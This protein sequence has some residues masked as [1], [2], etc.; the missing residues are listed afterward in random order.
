MSNLKSN[1]YMWAITCL[2]PDDGHRVTVAYFSKKEEADKLCGTKAY[3]KDQ[4]VVQCTLWTDGD[5]WYQ[6]EMREVGVDTS[7]IRQRAMA[8]LSD[9]EKRV[10]GLNGGAG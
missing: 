3:G 10:L 9:E 8:K 5:H 2:S 1:D 7:L 4:A 6:V